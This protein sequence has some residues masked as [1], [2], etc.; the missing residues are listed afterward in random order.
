[1]F[2]RS[3]RMDT[4]ELVVLM[5]FILKAAVCEFGFGE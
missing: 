1:M 5:V 4:S 2:L 3:H